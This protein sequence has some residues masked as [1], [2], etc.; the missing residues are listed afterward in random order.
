MALSLVADMLS[1]SHTMLAAKIKEL[2]RISILAIAY[3]AIEIAC[4]EFKITKFVAWITDKY[5]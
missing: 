5:L 4:A 2:E 3:V 1:A